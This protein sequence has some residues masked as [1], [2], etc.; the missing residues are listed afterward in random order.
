MNH[1]YES[2]EGYFT[3]PD[4]YSHIA[5]LAKAEGWERIVIVGVHNGTCAAYLAVELE[6]QGAATK[7]DLVDIFSGGSQ[8]VLDNL[9]PV[10]HRIDRV[11]ACN[12]W[13]AARFYDDGS[14][15]CVFI[16]ADHQ[17][18]SVKKD[19]EAW[20][21]KVRKDGFLSGHDYVEYSHPNGFNFGVIQAVKEAGL[22][23]LP[24]FLVW[25]GIKDGGDANMQGKHWP[26]WSVRL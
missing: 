11:L 8:R 1:F 4:W 19:I 12:S 26:V 21:P 5:R 18:D 10:L 15:D 6:N 20:R 25:Q 9:K 23:V 13:D 24:S 7:I 2:I 17:Y 16:D 3:Y 22:D 14:V